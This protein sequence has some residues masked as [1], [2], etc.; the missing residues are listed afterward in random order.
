VGRANF[1]T[2]LDSLAAKA[3][4]PEGAVRAPGLYVLVDFGDAQLVIALKEAEDRL[5]IEPRKLPIPARRRY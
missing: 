4:K 1:P 2:D 5:M 3:I